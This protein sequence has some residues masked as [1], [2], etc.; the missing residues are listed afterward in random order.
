MDEASG[1]RNSVTNDD[2][3][4]INVDAHKPVLVEVAGMRADL[5]EMRRSSIQR[6]E[7]APAI[8]QLRQ[9]VR[10]LRRANANLRKRLDSLW[11]R[12]LATLGGAAALI[13]VLI[14]LSGSITI[15]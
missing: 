13:Y 5:E 15:H 6:I 9:D 10:A 3:R 14:Q 11:T 7:Y 1:R 2:I 4:T 12:L 8:M